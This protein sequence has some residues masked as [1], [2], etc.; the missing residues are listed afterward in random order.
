[1]LINNS[2]EKINRPNI[3]NN[4][5]SL[6]NNINISNNQINNN[7]LNTNGKNNNNN[8]IININNSK[9]VTINNNTYNNNNDNSK[10]INDS[11]VPETKKDLNMIMFAKSKSITNSIIIQNP[12]PNI[13]AANSKR[14]FNKMKALPTSSQGSK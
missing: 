4:T 14:S 12:N 13:S 7:N 8:V 11:S 1:M 3:L 5:N 2:K 10:D 9:N 6:D